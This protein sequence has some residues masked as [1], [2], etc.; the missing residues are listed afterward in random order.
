MDNLRQID[1]AIQQWALDTKQGDT[2]TGGFI[3]STA[4]NLLPAMKN[5][6]IVAFAVVILNLLVSVPAAYALAQV[7][8]QV[9]HALLPDLAQ[10][11][12][13]FDAYSAFDKLGD[14]VVTG[15]TGNNVRDLRI[16]LAY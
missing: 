12:Q 3:P 2:A 13:G 11:L 6:F 15:P 16:L 4:S 1:G 14:T 10:A 8:G 9:V 5:S 7:H